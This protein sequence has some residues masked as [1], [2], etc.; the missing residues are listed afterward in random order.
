MKVHIGNWPKNGKKRIERVK[1]DRFD[2]TDLYIILSLI[3][4]PA[5]KQFKKNGKGYPP[6]FKD[7]KTWQKDGLNKMIKAFDEILKGEE[8]SANNI[9]EYYKWQTTIQEGLQLFAKYFQNLWH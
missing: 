3:I 8:K 9:E 2:S 5:L 4:L 1:I 6:C 7:E